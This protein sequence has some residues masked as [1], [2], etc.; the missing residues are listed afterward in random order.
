MSPPTVT[1]I[2]LVGGERIRVQGTVS[3]VQAKILDAARGS[4]MELAWLDDAESGQPVGV[5]PVHIVSI[6][7][8]A[9][10]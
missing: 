2:L 6:S 7:A 8:A 9:E 10:S 5:N 1:E 3:D 4:I